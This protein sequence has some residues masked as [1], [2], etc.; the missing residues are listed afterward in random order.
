VAS[1]LFL[2]TGNAARSVMA[3][4]MLRAHL[5]DAAVAT[6]GTHVIDGQP[7]SWRTRDAMASLGLAADSHRSAQLT[8]AALDAA[9]LVVAMAIEHVHYIRRRHPDAAART[10]TLRRLVRDLPS[11]PGTLDER[12]SAMRLHTVEPEPWEDVEDPAGGT[13]E[14]YVECARVLD[15]LVGRLADVLRPLVLRQESVTPPSGR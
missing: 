8:P 14:V 9:H 15:D 4:A 11:V 6:A 2:C 3:G 10:A 12:V 1:V 13:A 5:P 7:M